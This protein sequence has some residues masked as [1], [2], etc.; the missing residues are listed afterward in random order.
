MW[1]SFQ[2]PTT[3]TSSP[4]VLAEL[5]DHDR[6]LDLAAG[7]V[8]ACTELVNALRQQA[9]GRIMAGAY[10]NAFD[11]NTALEVLTT[12]AGTAWGGCG[13]EGGRGAGG[14][15]EGTTAAEAGGCVR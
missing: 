2:P 14:V 9:A 13:R 5:A 10:L 6:V 11:V 15:R 12:G 8:R 4:Q 3:T 1:D 7:H